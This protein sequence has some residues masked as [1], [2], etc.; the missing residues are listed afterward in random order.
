VTRMHGAHTCYSEHCRPWGTASQSQDKIEAPWKQL[1][2][3]QRLQ[4]YQKA[5]TAPVR[6]AA[7]HTGT[8]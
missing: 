3:R 4:A 2:R 1:Y 5:V 8:P 6:R 7:R